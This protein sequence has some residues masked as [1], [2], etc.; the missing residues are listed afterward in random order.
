MD[1]AQENKVNS[2]N[3]HALVQT[4][5]KLKYREKLLHTVSL[6]AERLLTADDSEALEALLDAMK[7]VGDCLNVDRVQI[8]RNEMIDEE[9]HFV[10]RYE[11]LSDVGKQKMIVP[12]GYSCAYSKCDGWYEKFSRGEPINAPLSALKPDEAEFLG[13][14]EMKALVILPLFMNGEFVGF[15]SVDDCKD[16]R[17]F[18][19]EEMNMLAS[20]G[21]ML[22][23]VFNKRLQAKEIEEAYKRQKDALNQAIAASSA[24]GEFLSI[25]SH[26]MRTPMNAIIGMISIAKSTDDPK[27][28]NE[29]LDKMSEAALHLLGVIN[30]V[31]DMS[32]IEAKKMEIL[33]VEFDMR[34]MLQKV[35]DLV[36]FKMEEKEHQF[37][38]EISPDVP[39]YYLG[40]D[41]RLTQ[42]I[43]N[44]LTNAVTHTP[45]NGKISLTVTKVAQED[46]ICELQFVVSDNGVGISEEHQARLFQ[47][48]EQVDVNR[49]QHGGS[50]LGLNICKRLVELMNGDIYVKSEVG[51]GSDFTFTVKLVH[52]D[53]A[54]SFDMTDLEPDESFNLSNIKEFAGKRILVAEDMEI[55]RE[56]IVSLLES[57]GIA[58]DTA[59]NGLI[60]LEMVRKNPPYDL[61]LMDM[62]MPEMDGLEATRQIRKMPSYQQNKVPIIAITANVFTDDIEKCKQAGM[63]DHIGKPFELSLII[64]KLRKYLTSE[65]YANT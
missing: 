62:R 30:D 3:E 40:D 61:I 54:E 29:A 46:E 20:T 57:T 25:M 52:V 45:K 27:R 17:V 48:F 16:E 49:R 8:W 7:I 51:K 35:L 65:I 53:K 19:K 2:A 36:K 58:I 6:V 50:G 23:S 64:G 12:L 55:N 34:R 60:A 63:D 14:Y 1:N 21:L 28:I 44:L 38:I 22:T 13:Y 39:R 43:I 32:K 15:F 31:L 26:E 11:W 10:M 9:M 24:K 56:I 18:S 47:M 59:E 42:I 33:P 5:I 41:Q 37:D 4:K